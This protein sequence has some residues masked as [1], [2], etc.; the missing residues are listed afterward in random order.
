MLKDGTV[1]LY[2]KRIAPNRDPV[3]VF[4]LGDPAYS[5]VPERVRKTIWR[6]FFHLNFLVSV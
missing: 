3:T 1:P 2:A 4:L 6:D 5:L